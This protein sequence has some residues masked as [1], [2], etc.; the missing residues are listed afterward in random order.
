MKLVSKAVLDGKHHLAFILQAAGIP[1]AQPY[2]QATQDHFASVNPATNRS[3]ERCNGI[4]NREF[5][6]EIPEMQFPSK[7]K[8]QYEIRFRDES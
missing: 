4:T 6:S 1:N 7:C 3:G 8:I 5:L 2:F